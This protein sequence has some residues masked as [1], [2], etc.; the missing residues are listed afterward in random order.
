MLTVALK[1][2]AGRKLRASLTALAIVLGVAMVSGTFVLTDTIKRGFDTIFSQ[3]YKNTD[4][5]VTGKTAF[6]GTNGNT[7]A[8]PSVPASLLAQVRAVPGVASAVGSIADEAQVIGRNGKAIVSGGAP[9]LAFGIDPKESRFNPLVLVAGSWASG[10]D[11]VVL[12]KATVEKQHFHVGQTVRVAARGPAQPFRLVGVARFG[13][14]SSIGGATLAIFDVPTAQQIFHKRG[15]LDQISIAAKSG[16]GAERLVAEVKPLLPRTARVRTA[17]DEAKV[18]SSDA[19]TFIKYI[20]YFLLTFGGIALFVGSFV[21]ANTLSITIAQ[22]TREFATLRT[23]GASRRQVRASVIVEALTIGIV[24][25]VVGLVLGFG[26]AKLLNWVLVQFG[27]DLPKSALVFAA[28]T[29]VV[30]LLVGIVVTLL[31]SLRPALRATRVPPIAAVREGATLP[32]GRFAG[33]KPYFALAVVALGFALLGIGLFEHGL[34][35]RNVLSLLG[36][37]CLLLFL[38]VALFAGTL[39]RPLARVLGWP[40]ATIGGAPGQLARENAS[41]NAGRT[42]STAAALMIGLALVSFVAVLASGLRTTF[43]SAV[44][45]VFHADYAVTA[46]NNFSP[47]FPSAGRALRDAPGVQV[48]AS[49]RG[50]VGRAFGKNVQVT[51]VEPASAT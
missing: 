15:E 24:A 34:G 6:S 43:R 7:T 37:G 51:A 16:V 49:I 45:D 10:A 44:Y 48:D 11:E 5:V 12:D 36:V 4:A 2:L 21:I 28:R 23:L 35:T 14:V 50:D 1:G 29:I 22:R 38:G 39:V 18:A 46:Q 9:N 26:L 3:S 25:S 17:T 13:A 19:T 40:S 31:A 41:R 30:S 27:I 42:A 32:P 8:A 47:L 33:W 20:R